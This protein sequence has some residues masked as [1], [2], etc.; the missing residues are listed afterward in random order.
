MVAKLVTVLVIVLGVITL[1]Q[2]M[3]LYEASNKLRNKGEHDIS[4]SDNDLNAKAMIAFMILLFGGFIWLMFKFGWGG[5]GPA[6]SEHGVEQD[7]LLNVNFVIIIAVFF[8]TNALLFIFSYKYVRK[9]GV[10]AYYFPH[11][12]KL[13]A[14]WTIA[15]AIVLAIIIILG[16]RQWNQVTSQ[17]DDEAIRVEL[18]SYQFGWDARYAGQD[19]V[20]GKF[21]YKLTTDK[22]PLALLTTESIDEAIEVMENGPAG[23]NALESQ[24]N[25]ENLMLIPDDREKMMTDLDRKERLI[26]LLYQMK[27]GHNPQVDAYAWDDIIQKDT[28]Y[29][30][31]GTQYEFNFRAKD[32]I[33]SAYFPHFRAQMNTVPGQTTRFKFT[34]TISTDEMRVIRNDENFNFILFCNKICGGSHYKMRMFIKVLEPKE[35]DAWMAGKV[36]STFKNSFFGSTETGPALEESTQEE[37]VAEETGEEPAQDPTLVE[38]VIE[39]AEGVVSAE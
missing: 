13:E 12:N 21:D 10:K 32:V 5:L 14:A 25:D 38:Q 31:K 34:P 37:N 19:N 20:L 6:A 35:Y 26:R 22:N 39:A 2:L 17:A 29:L 36:E 8:I 7:W 3:R 33:H 30:K 15:P 1:A 9:A 18:F 27:R 11:D 24:L 4:N 28:L 16:L 23:I